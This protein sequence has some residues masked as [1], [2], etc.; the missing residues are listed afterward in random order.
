[1]LLHLQIGNVRDNRFH[2]QDG[3]SRVACQEQI[4]GANLVNNNLMHGMPSNNLQDGIS[5]CLL[6]NNNN[7]QGGALKILLRSSLLHGIPRHLPNSNPRLGMLKTLLNSNLLQ[8]GTHRARLLN[9]LLGGTRRVQQL[10][11]DNNH[12]THPLLRLIHGLSLS[13]VLRHGVSK[14]NLLH[15][16]LQRT[17]MVAVLASRGHNQHK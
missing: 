5:K 3:T 13:R 6:N 1:M 14:V 12:G 4:L 9:S 16:H 15:L 17:E 7:P 10:P 11:G 8:D 2:H